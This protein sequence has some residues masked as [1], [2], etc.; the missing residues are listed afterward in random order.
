MNTQNAFTRGTT[1]IETILQKMIGLN[2]K[3]RSVIIEILMLFLSFRGRINFVQLGRQGSL[4]ERSYRNHFEKEFDWMTFNAEVINSSISSELFIGF[5]PSYI[6][7]SGKK[8]P[9][10]GYYYSGVACKYKRGLEI[11]NIAVIDRI[12]NTAYHLECVMTP[13]M[14]K[15]KKDG[16]ECKTLVDHY[17]QV[18]INRKEKLQ[19]LSSILVVDGYF[20]KRKFIDA[21][22][23]DTEMEVICRLRDDANLQYLYKG[24]KKGRGRPK[25]Y[26]G[27]V[28]VKKIDKRRVKLKESNEQCRIYE[29]ELYSVGLKRNIQLCYVEF[30]KENGDV[31]VI[32][33]FF[34]TNMERPAEEILSY[35]RARFQMEFLFRDAK[36]FTGL[37]HC[38]AR[39]KNKLNFHFNASLT[40][41][42]IAK[43]ILRKDA[44]P[45]E[46]MSYSISDLKIK[47]Q[48]RNIIY[49]I[50]SMYGID[51]KL[52][53]NIRKVQELIS[54]GAIAA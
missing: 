9:G 46:R 28:N 11:G 6:S 31:N 45:T 8:T 30:L 29:V 4:S 44:L 32:K 48:N 50:F 24:E 13:T 36:Q 37:Q 34:S 12:Q 54:F 25:K 23:N 41:L 5:D 18:I 26:D 16:D 1:L 33:L 38:Q 21:I 19:N 7:K 43:R 40:S 14:V 52:S 15:V 17:A 47:L 2:V 39:S 53:K 35:Y 22:S 42:N 27:K 49:R 3:R 10:L 51:R 20:A